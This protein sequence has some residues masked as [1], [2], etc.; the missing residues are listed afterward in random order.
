M[1][2]KLFKE[3]WSIESKIISNISLSTKFNGKTIPK[4]RSSVIDRSVS[5]LRTRRIRRTSK[6]VRVTTKMSEKKENYEGSE[7]N[8]DKTVDWKEESCK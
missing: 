3:L 1:C 7:E 8:E 6:R 5:W 4:S 2:F